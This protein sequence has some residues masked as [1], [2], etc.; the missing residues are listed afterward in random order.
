MT[1][2]K[3]FPRLRFLDDNGEAYPEWE[4]KKLG[5]VAELKHGYPFNSKDFNEYGI[6]KI[7]TI[8]NVSNSKYVLNTKSNMIDKLPNNLKEHQKLKIGDLLISLTGN[9]GRISIVNNNHMLLNQ[10][11]GLLRS[12]TVSSEYLYQVLKAHNFE[13]KMMS[14]AYGSAQKNLSNSHILD[15]IVSVPSLPEQEKIANFLSALDEN[16]EA[17]EKLLELLKVEKTGYL[18]KIFNRELRFMDDNGE[19]YPDWEMKTL[20][21]V[22]NFEKGKQINKD[23]LSETKTDD[24]PYPLYNGGIIHSGYFSKS[25]NNGYHVTISE[26]GNAGYVRYVKGNFWSGGHNY[27]VKNINCSQNFIFQVLKYL[28]KTL[29]NNARGTTIKNLQKKEINKI[30]ITIPSSLPEQEKIAD[31]LSA[32]DDRIDA[33]TELIKTLKEEKKGY[34][35]RIFG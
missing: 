22:A 31:F 34:Q 18:Q 14:L 32:I 10:R 13:H 1:E 2:V 33:Q 24:F 16:I 26:G 4:M 27:I 6:Y 25:N 8:S 12:N 20:G 35:Q 3:N 17:N 30:S 21:E 23:Q 5:E 29:Q 15:F 11:V 28:E 7:V 19:A 9:C